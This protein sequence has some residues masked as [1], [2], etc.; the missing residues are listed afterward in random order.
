MTVGFKNGKNIHN[1][2]YRDHS[3]ITFSLYSKI[4]SIEG[5]DKYILHRFSM[6]FQSRCFE[7]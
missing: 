7:V 5:D 4:K 2:I 3:N 1:C 6:F